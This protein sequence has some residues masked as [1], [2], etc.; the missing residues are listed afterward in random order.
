MYANSSFITS[1]QT[2]IHKNLATLVKK[3]SNTI[4]NKPYQSHNLKAFEILLKLIPQNTP[5]ILDAGCGV[6]ESSFNL[7]KIYQNHFI[8][9]VDQSFKRLERH[10]ESNYFCKDNILLLRADLI[11]FWRLLVENNIMIAKHFILYPNPY[12]KAKHIK[13]RWHGHPVFPY[14][15]NI[16]NYLE[17]RSNWEIY[18]DEFQQAAFILKNMQLK[19]SNLVP[20]H[21]ISPFEKKYYDSGHRLYQLFST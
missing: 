4:F 16:G 13:Q 12:P 7:G 6:G 21:S 15:L 19:K 11:D 5:L 8:I 17:I 9:G 18:I 10:I 3:H 14:L 20:I 2:I 1:N